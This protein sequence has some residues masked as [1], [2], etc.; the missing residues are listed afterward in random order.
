MSRAPV[1]TSDTRRSRRTVSSS[2]DA[3]RSVKQD[4]ACVI[5][6]VGYETWQSIVQVKTLP[7]EKTPVASRAFY[8]MQEIALTCALTFPKTS[9]HLCEAPGG[10]VQAMQH[11]SDPSWKWIAISRADGPKPRLQCLPMRRGSFVEANIL[12]VDHCQS[13]LGYR[14]SCIVTADGA[15]EMNHDHLEEEHFSL[16][17]AQTR[18]AL[19]TLR[20]GGTLI[21]KFFEGGEP[22]TQMWVA[23]LCSM[24][25][26]VSIIKPKSSRPT[27]SELYLVARD[28]LAHQTWQNVNTI[29]TAADW[30]C[31]L[32]AVI[33]ELAKNQ[34]KALRTAIARANAVLKAR[35]SFSSPVG[36]QT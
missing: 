13:L 17:D 24:F 19:Y 4:A 26:N 7:R 15:T 25:E 8:K 27:N 12:D 32:E 1:C 6:S 23:Q 22:C 9:V 36:I 33:D 30:L 29:E 18:V 3:L 2:I 28:Y 31:D 11:I 21:I 34:I 10:F 35:A 20:K 5:E 14:S 16:L